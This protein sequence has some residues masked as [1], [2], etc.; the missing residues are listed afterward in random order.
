MPGSPAAAPP[1]GAG[2]SS[3]REPGPS[4]GTPVAASTPSQP[5]EKPEEEE[6]E[7]FQF[8]LCEGCGQD[9]PHPRL[10]R[11]LHTLCPG[12]LG[13][14]KPAGQCPL[15]HAPVPAAVDNLLVSNLQSRLKVWR[16]IRSSGGAGC[17]RCRVERALVWCSDC[18]EFFCAR[19][20]EEHQ[21]WHKRKEHRVRKVEEMRAGSARAFLE[22]TRSSCSLFC[23]SASHPEESRVCSIYCPRCER[24]LCCPCALLDTRHAPFRD[25]RAESRRRQ[26]ELRSLRRDL[27][28]LRGAF[29]AALLRLRSESSWQEEQRERLRDCVQAS[30]ERLQQLVRSEAEELRALLE[31]RPESGR[32]ELVEELR[33]VEGTLQRLE[34]AERVVDRLGRYGGEQELMDMQP[35]VKGALLELQRLRPP[36]PAEVREPQDFAECR[37]RLRALVERVTGRPGAD[38]PEVKVALEN[39][40]EEDPIHPKNQS[41][42]P[43]PEEIHTDQPLPLSCWNKRPLPCVERGSQISPKILKLECD[44]VPGPSH[45]ESHW[46]FQREPRASTSRHNCSRAEDTGVAPTELWV[47]PGA[48]P[49][50]VDPVG[51]PIPGFPL[52]RAAAS[53]SPA[54]TTA[55]RTPWWWR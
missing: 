43:I 20:L 40:P 53:S 41:T 49:G 7:D 36:E 14:A 34:A 52:Q 30:A 55:T 11:C 25:L 19:C 22:D 32:S 5:P 39:N 2:P 33:S 47:V 45:L 13:T 27:R 29:E 54:R 9:S 15:C 51:C 37:A 31:A 24:A 38:I 6:E 17:S 26:D 4:A 50:N 42:S 28:Q 8:L 48:N 21:W 3:P 44:H 46:E 12:C 18:E 10:L 23:T 35:F 16:Q 1:D